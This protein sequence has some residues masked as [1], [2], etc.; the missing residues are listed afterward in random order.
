MSNALT[1]FTARR[2]ENGGW[3]VEGSAMT[4][5]GHPYVPL[6]S[7]EYAY[8]SLPAM[9]AG[10]CALCH[11]KTEMERDVAGAGMMSAPFST[12]TREA[13]RQFADKP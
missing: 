3:I 5:D 4:S 12:A 2:T 1:T 7:K 11:E 8:E 9:L 13:M 6:G 10:L